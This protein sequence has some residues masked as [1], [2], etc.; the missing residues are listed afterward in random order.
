M[1]IYHWVCT[2]CGATEDVVKPLAEI[3]ETPPVVDVDSV[4]VEG[5]PQHVHLWERLMTGSRSW[6]RGANWG[7]G[8]KGSW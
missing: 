5:Q 2:D 6:V 7:E 4:P 1:P 3:N 8:R